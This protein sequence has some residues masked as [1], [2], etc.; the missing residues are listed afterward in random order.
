M[1]F[2][3]GET[4]ADR[5]YHMDKIRALQEETGVFTAFIPW[6]F[7]PGNSDLDRPAVGAHDYLRTLAVSRLY[8]ENVENLQ[9]SWVTQ[10]SEI[11]Q[12]AMTSGAND[13]G[14]TMIEENVVAAAGCSHTMDES[15]LIDL[16]H[17]AGYDAAQRTTQYDLVKKYPR[18]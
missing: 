6:P 1:V 2:G 7:Q 8:L 5:V 14:S 18:D 11:T 10:G 3:M 9:A 17:Q 4:L 13:I 15:G 12:I 16:I